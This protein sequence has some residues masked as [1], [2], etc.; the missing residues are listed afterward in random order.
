MSTSRGSGEFGNVLG[1]DERSRRPTFA[2][3]RIDRSPAGIVDR[4]NPPEGAVTPH[5]RTAVR[6]TD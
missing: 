2:A 3:S 4:F 6:L 5:P 1:D